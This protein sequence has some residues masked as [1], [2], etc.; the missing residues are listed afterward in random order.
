MLG[1]A[2]LWR[3]GVLV[4][5]GLLGGAL[6]QSRTFS[7]DLLPRCA[8][9]RPRERR[10]P[11]KAGTSLGRALGG[12]S[13][14]LP[15]IPLR[16]TAGPSSRGC[17]SRGG[18][19]APTAVALPA[20]AAPQPDSSVASF[21]SAFSRFLVALLPERRLLLLEELLEL[22]SGCLL[23]LRLRLVKAPQVFPP[24]LL[25]KPGGNPVLRSPPSC[26]FSQG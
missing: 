23:P 5:H 1:L 18:L 25:W 4:T 17:R 19:T 22:L 24:L 11:E 2:C 20:R 7:L 9:A 21:L 12:F 14:T 10:R 15:G 13:M 6:G 16:P 26:C 8:Q 3:H